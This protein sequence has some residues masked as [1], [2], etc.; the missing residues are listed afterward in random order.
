MAKKINCQELLDQLADYLDED[1]RADLCATIQEH[2]KACRDCS[3]YVDSIRK[4][5][6]LY[7][8]DQKIEAPVRVSEKLRAAMLAAY[9]E[10][11]TGQD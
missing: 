2:L 10:G 4:T 3:V 11:V 9:E 7:H 8:A 1:A 5:I 6:V